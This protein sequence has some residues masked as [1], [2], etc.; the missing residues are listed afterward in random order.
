MTEQL[1]IIGNGMAAGRV[2]ETLTEHGPDRYDVTVLGAETRPNYNRILLSP[3]LSGEKEFAD[4]VTHPE[5]WYAE[6]GFALRMGSRAVAIDRAARC[7]HLAD[8]GPQ[9]YDRLVIAHG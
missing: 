1:V 5:A 8:G 9:P 4:I 7:V 6:H 2:L 3:V